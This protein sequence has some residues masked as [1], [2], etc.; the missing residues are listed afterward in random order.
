MM[1]DDADE[2]RRNMQKMKWDR[3]KKKYVT[4]QSTLEKTK[5]IKTESGNYINASYK[6]GQ[7]LI[8][9]NS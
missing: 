5:K 3:K 4:V 6:S 2:I 1:G 9:Q 8:F 7:I